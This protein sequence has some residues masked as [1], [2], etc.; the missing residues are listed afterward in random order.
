MARIAILRPR[1]LR[2]RRIGHPP[3]D[4]INPVSQLPEC[5]RQLFFHIDKLPAKIG[6]LSPAPVRRV[7]VALRVEEGEVHG[8]TFKVPG[9]KLVQE[10]PGT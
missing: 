10:K 2:P 8:S 4:D 7:E 5:Q 9:S 1:K 6:M 3:R